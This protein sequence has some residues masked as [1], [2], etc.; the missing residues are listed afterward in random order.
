MPLCINDSG[1]WRCV[2]TL[3]YNDAGTWRRIRLGYAH[4]G[5]PVGPT[6]T[7]GQFYSQWK[8]FGFDVGPGDCTCGGVIICQASNIRWIV[9]RSSTTVRRTWDLRNDAVTTAQAASGVTGW[10]IPSNI[11]LQDIGTPCCVWWDYPLAS[12]PEVTS[13]RYWSGTENNPTLARLVQIG[14]YFYQNVG[15]TCPNGVRAWRCIT[16]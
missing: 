15:K 10:F 9:A 14:T 13:C 4:S 5:I 3:C 8:K 12:S 1:T 16:Y 7:S 6:F 2:A 11:Q